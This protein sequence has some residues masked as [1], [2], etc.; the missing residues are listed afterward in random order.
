MCVYLSFCRMLCYTLPVRL[1]HTHT[2]THTHSIFVPFLTNSSHIHTPPLY[3]VHT[4]STSHHPFSHS[5]RLSSSS[6]ILPSPSHLPPSLTLSHSPPSFPHSTILTLSSHSSSHLPTF[7]L[8][9]PSHLPPSTHRPLSSPF[10]PSLLHKRKQLS[11]KRSLTT[12]LKKS[13]FWK[14]KFRVSRPQA[15]EQKR[16][17]PAVR[18]LS[19]WGQASIPLHQLNLDRLNNS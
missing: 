18:Y 16:T 8:H 12:K 3:F 9:S 5:Y 7:P 15:W 11:L 13:S 1:S 2:H 6:D 17:G 14:V 4:F 10:P 19:G